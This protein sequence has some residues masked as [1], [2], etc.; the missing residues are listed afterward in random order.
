M[1]I[2]REI[3]KNVKN[4]HK[5]A[6]KSILDDLEIFEISSFLQRICKKAQTRKVEHLRHLY[7]ENPSQKWHA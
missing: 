4:G 2:N 1:K 7:K 6:L 5:K 3:L